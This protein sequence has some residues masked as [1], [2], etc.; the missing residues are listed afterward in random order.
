MKRA[1]DLAQNGG[2]FESAKVLGGCAVLLAKWGR[3][4]EAVSLTNLIAQPEL[5]KTTQECVSTILH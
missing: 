5:R 4:E 2:D 3:G 1:I